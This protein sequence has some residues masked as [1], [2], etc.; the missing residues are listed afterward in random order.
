MAVDI[1]G[2]TTAPLSDKKTGNTTTSPA[3]TT[4]PNSRDS[5]NV[6]SPSADTM[7][8]T[9]RAEELRMLETNIKLQPD[10]DSEKVE[11]L[12]VKIDAGR[13]DIDPLRVAEKLIEFEA[14]FVA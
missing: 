12:K 6:A 3:H 5:G 4:N 8:L 13:Y 10:I 1:T 7:T 9:Q 11:S 2:V 14:Q